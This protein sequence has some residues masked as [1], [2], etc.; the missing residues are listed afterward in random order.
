MKTDRKIIESW[1][2]NASP[3]IKAIEEKQIDSRRLT[4]D[5]A[6]VDTLLS[7]SLSN[8][9]DIG[10]GEGWLVRELSAHGL[11]VTGIDAIKQLIDKAKEQQEGSYR[12]LEYENISPQSITEKYSAL[13]CNF[14][15][16]GKESVEHIFNMAPLILAKRGHL[17]IQTLNPV[18][19]CGD[20][21]YVD[22]WRDG[23]WEGF[24]NDFCNPAPWYFRTL[25]TWK[26]LYQDNGFELK[27]IKEPIHSTTKNAASLIMVGQQ[28]I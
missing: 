19:S 4:T 20:Q 13:V 6:I 11:S 26:N 25:E 8:V 16:I 10:C 28:C 1:K 9:L 27:Q 12:V 15:L 23:S 21:A 17:I 5:K 18:T 22:G 3:W 14:S 2:Q 24:S 7:L